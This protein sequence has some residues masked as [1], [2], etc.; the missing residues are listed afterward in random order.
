MNQV[1]ARFQA[2]YDKSDDFIKPLFI[3]LHGPTVMYPHNLRS[4]ATK[5]M[6]YS[7]DLHTHMRPQPTN[8]SS[9]DT[10][11]PVPNANPAPSSSASAADIP[12]Q[13]RTHQYTKIELRPGQPSPETV[14]SLVWNLLLGVQNEVRLLELTDEEGLRGPVSHFDASL[15]KQTFITAVMEFVDMW[16]H[17]R[18]LYGKY[19]LLSRFG[20]AVP[21][22]WVSLNSL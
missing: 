20:L 4:F 19:N 3:A 7:A 14:S 8:Q 11:K 17:L 12:H 22:G 9:A 2:V 16:P 1:D 21:S 6:A 15:L 18:F 5:M 10:A 13:R